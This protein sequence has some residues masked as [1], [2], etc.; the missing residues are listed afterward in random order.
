MSWPVYKSAFVLIV[1]TLSGT[2]IGQQN[3]RIQELH[4]KSQVNITGTLR[5]EWR[6]WRRC[7]FLKAPAPYRL[8]FDAQESS[9]RQVSEIEIMLPGQG[10][11]LVQYAGRTLTA[12]GNLQFDPV[13]PYYCNGAIII[14][15]DVSLP[16]SKSLPA[17]SKDT[18][19]PASIEKYVASVILIPRSNWKF[20]AQN[21]SGSSLG[22][23]NLAGC[24]L[25]GGGD[26]LNCY[27]VQGFK[28][29]RGHSITEAVQSEGEDLDGFFQFELDEEAKH[30]VT[31]NVECVRAK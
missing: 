30:Q 20:S 29:V 12:N 28:P 2:M 17:R 11:D 8:M 4:D 10:D 22:T 25:N 26:V 31:I 7:L 5:V 16:N 3:P 15:K 23:Q 14:A 9:P 27:C 18:A 19:V 1:L 13:S 6:G 24:S 21:P